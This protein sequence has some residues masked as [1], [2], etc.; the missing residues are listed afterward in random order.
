[1][2]ESFHSA[3]SRCKTTMLNHKIYY[4][5]WAV[6]SFVCFRMFSYCDCYGH[7][8]CE[9]IMM[10]CLRVIHSNFMHLICRAGT[11]ANSKFFRLDDFV[12]VATE[13]PFD[14]LQCPLKRF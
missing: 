9:C 7:D 5:E 2:S 14:A 3:Q 4:E 12:Q 10:F 8:V 13:F 6:C 1:M 11:A